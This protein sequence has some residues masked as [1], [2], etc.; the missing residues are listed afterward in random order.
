MDQDFDAVEIFVISP[1]GEQKTLDDMI[2]EY[3][4]DGTLERLGLESSH[5]RSILERY[6]ELSIRIG[7]NEVHMLSAERDLEEGL[8]GMSYE[9]VLE[10]TANLDE[11]TADD[12]LEIYRR[13]NADAPAEEEDEDVFPILQ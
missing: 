8:K 10:Q 6:L 1:D 12:I 3:G 11:E 2:F 13:V 9:E 4:V 5:L 7:R